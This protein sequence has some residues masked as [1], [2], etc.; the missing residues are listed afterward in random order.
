MAYTVQASRYVL[1]GKAAKDQNKPWQY[2][3]EARDSTVPNFK[4]GT[5]EIVEETAETDDLDL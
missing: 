3:T 1:L 4:P 5:D 2:K